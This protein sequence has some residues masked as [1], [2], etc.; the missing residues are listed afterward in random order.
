MKLVEFLE[1]HDKVIAAKFNILVLIRNGNERLGH[2]LI[3]NHELEQELDSIFRH[4]EFLEK[5]ITTE[6]KYN[7]ES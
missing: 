7:G 6:R 4:I 5:T 3:S 1:S 2:E